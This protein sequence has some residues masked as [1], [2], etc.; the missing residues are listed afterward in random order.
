[1][2]NVNIAK[3]VITIY[4]IIGKALGTHQDGAFAKYVIAR[5]ESVHHLPENV[6]FIS[7]AMTEPLACT[8]HAIEKVKFNEGDLVV[9]TGPGPIG[10]LAAQVAKSQKATVIITGIS[11]DKLRLDKAKE[12][13]LIMQ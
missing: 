8:Y 13:G 11:N 7:A 3:H 9:V 5:K 2:E 6:D 10:L 1:M 12:L 4:A